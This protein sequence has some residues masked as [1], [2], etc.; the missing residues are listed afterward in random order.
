MRQCVRVW[1]HYLF[2]QVVSVLV[3]LCSSLSLRLKTNFSDCTVSTFI[4]NILFN[5]FLIFI[6]SFSVFLGI[7]VDASLFKKTEIELISETVDKI[8]ETKETKIE[9]GEYDYINGGRKEEILIMKN[10]ENEKNKGT[11]E[12]NENNKIEELNVTNHNDENSDENS[13]RNESSNNNSQNNSN[14]NSSNNSQKN[15]KFQ[16]IEYN[17][18]ST[19][20]FLDDFSNSFYV[21]EIKKEE[22]QGKS[23]KFIVSKHLL[24]MAEDNDIFVDDYGKNIFSCVKLIFLIDYFSL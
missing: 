1:W 21:R 16:K 22:K 7:D 10:K 6:F 14:C 19:E 18:K 12:D 4:Q 15:S 20:K 2:S 3:T 9:N 11:D 5:I 23:V 13:I 8:G 17:T 24:K